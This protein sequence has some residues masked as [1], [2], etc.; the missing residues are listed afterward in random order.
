MTHQLL[1][2]GS[3]LDGF[4]IGEKIHSGGMATLWRVTKPGIDV[5]IVMKA[6]AILDGD[7][8]TIV[9]FTPED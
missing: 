5:P 8:A 2:T 4:K 3:T 9:L 1:Q 6:P 7:D